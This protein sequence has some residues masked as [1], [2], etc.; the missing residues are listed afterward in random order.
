[1]TPKSCSLNLNPTF[2]LITLPHHLKALMIEEL[3]FSE[4]IPHRRWLLLGRRDVKKKLNRSSLETGDIKV[5]WARLWV[6]LQSCLCSYL[7]REQLPRDGLFAAASAQTPRTAMPVLEPGVWVPAGAAWASPND[8][9]V[10]PFPLWRVHGL[11]QCLCLTHVAPGHGKWDINKAKANAEPLTYLQM[12]LLG[13]FVSVIPQSTLG[14][15]DLLLPGIS[16]PCPFSE[17][18]LLFHSEGFCR[19]TEELPLGFC[20]SPAK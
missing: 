9:K 16:Y 2:T 6:P 4:P 1:M 3:R 8:G 17:M 7:C 13:L 10:L 5:S 15:A 18:E 14:E 12:L 20:V 11:S 19:W